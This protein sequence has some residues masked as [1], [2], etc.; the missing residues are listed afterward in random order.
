MSYDYKERKIVC[1][2]SDNLETWQAMNVIGHLAVGLGANKDGELMGRSI[3]KDASDIDH[4]GIAKYGF[5]IK[6]GNPTAIREAIE[7]SRQVK[8]FMVLDFPREMLDTSHDDELSDLIS[9][10]EEKDFEYLGAIFY[11][12]SSEINQ[13]TKKFPLWS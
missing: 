12:P 6:K 13:L 9:K 11:G 10:K 3:L 4:L 7:T 1:V 2:V 8:N 5:I